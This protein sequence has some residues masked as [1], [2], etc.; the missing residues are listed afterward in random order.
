[1]SSTLGPSACCLLKGSVWHH[2]PWAGVSS[3]DQG[4]SKGQIVTLLCIWGLNHSYLFGTS[5]Y[6]ADWSSAAGYSYLKHSNRSK[7]IRTFN[8]SFKPWILWLKE[9]F[10][11]KSKSSSINQ[12]L[13]TVPVAVF[14]KYVFFPIILDQLLCFI[15]SLQIIFKND[16]SFESCRH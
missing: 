10:Q 16:I 12:S 8:F 14:T 2:H 13:S 5:C 7:L 1:M 11:V 9:M 4:T 15:S 3:W 6:C